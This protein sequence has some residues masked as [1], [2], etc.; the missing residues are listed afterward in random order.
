[1][2]NDGTEPMVISEP[3]GTEDRLATQG[4]ITPTNTM[5]IEVKYSE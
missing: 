2:P 4:A 3:E 5:K 1:M